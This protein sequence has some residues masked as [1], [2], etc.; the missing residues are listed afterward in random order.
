MKAFWESHFK[1]EGISW[2]F[3]PSDSAL[4]A[5][6]RFKTEGIKN[7]LIPGFG[8]GR[9]ARVFCDS[10][11][12]VTGIEVSKTAVDLAA[13][14]GLKCKIHLGSVSSMPFDDDMYDGIFCY[15]LLHLLNQTERLCFIRNCYNQLKQG[16]IMVFT[17][18]SKTSEMYGAGS[19]LSRDRFL[20]KN[21]LKVFFY[22]PDSIQKAFKNYGSL[23]IIEHDEPIKFRKAELPLKCITVVSKKK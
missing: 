7:I 20:I 22:D 21:G 10:G 11:F 14:N 9:N 1:N 8:Y 12:R 16:G 4:L 13:I 18:I 23:E 5:L 6:E 15:A 19:R 2:G 3:E 17:V